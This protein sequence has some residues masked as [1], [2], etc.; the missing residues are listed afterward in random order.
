MSNRTSLL[1]GVFSL[2]LILSSLLSFVAS[3]T[4]G[5]ETELYS[6]SSY[7]YHFQLEQIFEFDHLKPSHDFY[8]ALLPADSTL[9]TLQV[10]F[11]N[12][13]PHRSYVE[14]TEFSSGKHLAEDS[15]TDPEAVLNPP[16]LIDDPEDY[17]EIAIPV[18]R[19]NKQAQVWYLESSSRRTTSNEFAQADSAGK[20]AKSRQFALV[21]PTLKRVVE[22]SGAVESLISQEL[23]LLAAGDFDHRI[24]GPEL[25]LQITLVNRDERKHHSQIR[26]YNLDSWQELWRFEVP[27]G[28]LMHLGLKDDSDTITNHLF[29]LRGD[30][31]GN[32][33]NGI[34]DTTSYAVRLSL[35]G[36][37]LSE[38]QPLGPTPDAWHIE[39]SYPL[40]ERDDRLL[41]Y[42][43]DPDGDYSYLEILDTETLEVLNHKQVPFAEGCYVVPLGK[44][45]HVSFQVVL[46]RNQVS[47]LKYNDQLELLGE[48]VLDEPSRLL[49]W[50]QGLRGDGFAK[51][52][53]HFLLGSKQTGLL[54]LLSPKFE[55]LSADKIQEEPLSTR[56]TSLLY[57]STVNPLG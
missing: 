19:G 4:K 23:A 21:K 53:T 6:P 12:G 17:P 10:K 51:P 50:M 2:L 44:D 16:I 35:D 38:P 37:L 14:F 20:Q 30:Y 22:T 18:M 39:S 11:R 55:I 28:V 27:C 5:D 48:L 46:F 47:F 45:D 33:A 29:V 52:G 41:M 34:T 49:F 56:C 40:P 8:L 13:A 57:S 36:E 7:R 31:Q 9:D 43:Y 15:T 54:I 32:S 24:D 42:G 25:L 26:C 3:A 1:I